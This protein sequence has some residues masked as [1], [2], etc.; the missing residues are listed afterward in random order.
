MVKL[1]YLFQNAP[2]IE[3]KSLM[4][5][6]RKK[7]PD[8]IFF[9]VKGMMFNGHRFINQAIENGAK[10]IVHSESLEDI[11]PDITYIKVKNVQQ[12]FN[13][14]ADAFYGRASS[15]L[16]MFGI[17]GT[18]GKSSVA[19][20]IKDL[21]DEYEPTGYIGTIA[22]EYGSVKLEPTLTTQLMIYTVF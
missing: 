2:D 16:R 14:V 12:A 13:S 8:S 19:S 20:L 15:K 4:S 1:S 11:N 18:N 9:C 10:V 22:I 5:D 3:I 6:S 17:T 21:L 7:R